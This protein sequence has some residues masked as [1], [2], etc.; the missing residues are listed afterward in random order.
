MQQYLKSSYLAGI[1]QLTCLTMVHSGD[2]CLCLALCTASGACYKTRRRLTYKVLTT[3]QPDYLHNLISVQSTG[4]TRS[5]SAVIL[6]WPFVS[7][8]L[9]ITNCAFWYASPYPSASHQPYP[10]HSPPG[11]P[12]SACTILSQSPPSLHLPQPFTPETQ[13]FRKSFNP[14]L[15][16]LSGSICTVILDF[17]SGPDLL[18]TGLCLFWFLL[19]YFYFCW[20]V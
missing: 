6:A 15:H 13:L 8:S 11:L 4:R 2:W 14:F 9:Q 17:G 20:C 12:H 18:G 7:S 10:I 16:S 1:K 5:S 19:L 3:S